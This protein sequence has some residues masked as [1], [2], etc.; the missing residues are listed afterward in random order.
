MNHCDFQKET[1]YMDVNRVDGTIKTVLPPD[2]SALAQWQTATNPRAR[3]R[4]AEARA[5]VISLEHF[6]DIFAV[7][8]GGHTADLEQT[9]TSSRG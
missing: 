1:F 8:S 9:T 6:G 4:R 7:P 5:H 3:M 2:P